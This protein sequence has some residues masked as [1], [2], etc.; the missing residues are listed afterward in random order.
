[1]ANPRP[2][3][4][5]ALAKFLPDQRSIRAFEQ[6]FDLIPEDLLTLLSA[7]DEV[8]IDAVTAA[9][10]AQS[11]LDQLTRIADAVEE[12]AAR[13]NAPQYNFLRG[14]YLDFPV[15]GPHI[16][17][18]RRLQWNDDDGTLDVGLYGGSVLQ[19]GQ[20]IMYYAKNTSGAS[21]SN[22]TPVMFTGTVGASG[23][24]TFGKAVAD[25]SIHPENMMGVAT[26][27]ID[28]NA[29]GYVTS[30]GLVRGLDTSGTPYSETWNDGDLLYFD[31][32]TAGT[33]TNVQPS[34]PSISR[35]VAVVIY[36]TSGNSGSIFVR[37][38]VNEGLHDLHDVNIAS[39][40][41]NDVLVYN[42]SN[43]RW[44]NSTSVT[45]ALTDTT[46]NLLASSATLTNGSGAATGTLTNA[47]SAGNPTKWV[48]ID[49]N[50]TTRYIPTW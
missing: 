8:G 50:G 48:A 31:P 18:E 27:D 42:S 41:N 14:D 33:W 23:K 4:R 11:A 17:R 36:A 6:L 3:T 15:N 5:A 21:I 30:F 38:E 34:A 44:E 49:D 32:A 16:Q 45:S 47:P 20:E 1:M 12:L 7:I 29:F 24:L 2:L 43:T 28:N 35:A 37:M 25:G 10:K 22:G 26:Q 40:A 9:A 39:A 19:V 46:T 13:P